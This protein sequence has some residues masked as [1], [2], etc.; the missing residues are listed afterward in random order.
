MLSSKALVLVLAAA[1]MVLPERANAQ[2]TSRRQR[3]A[4]A[5]LF[6]F[7]ASVGPFRRTN[8]TNFTADGSNSAASYSSKAGLITAY[9]YPARAPYS[10]S[11]APHFDQCRQ[12][13]RQLWGRTRSI[14]KRSTFINRNGRAYPGIEEV[15]SGK[16]GS[17]DA[18][19]ALLVF[20]ADDRYVKFRFTT[21]QTGQPRSS[22]R[23]ADLRSGEAAAQ[24]A[25][26]VA[27]LLTGFAEKFPWPASRQAARLDSRSA[28]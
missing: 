12:E 10:P 17:R 22:T 7:P 24:T 9:V 5:A 21:L 3:S 19:S 25:G 1:A 28:E 27:G 11:L 23:E 15:F 26:R 20:K 16:V 2:T 8:V 18:V 6:K 13:V 14:S 4:G